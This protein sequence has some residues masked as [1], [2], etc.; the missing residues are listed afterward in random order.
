MSSQLESL[1]N[2]YLF[3][4]NASYVEELYEAYLDNP[5]TVP[6]VWR[7]YFDQLQNAPAVDGF[8]TTRDQT[9][10]PIVESFA[11][12]ARNNTLL[13]AAK[14]GDLAVAS[15]QVSVQSLIAAYRSLGTRVANLD[16]L[17]RH[18]RPYI[19]E[20]DPAFYGLTEA[21][22]DEV[23][24]LGER[25]QHFCGDPRACSLSP[26]VHLAGSQRARRPGVRGASAR[27]DAGSRRQPGAPPD[28]RYCRLRPS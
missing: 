12:R 20:L 19:P 25:L 28:M 22:L 6:D 4:S 21:D 26:V 13:R 7:E 16:P 23:Q 17:K 11:L 10:S 18:E 15:K 9:H 3:G 8:Q 14:G 2:S 5:G 24:K 27:R 1:S